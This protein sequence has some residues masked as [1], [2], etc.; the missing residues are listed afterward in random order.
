M[1][2]TGSR[3]TKNINREP[4]NVMITIGIFYG[5]LTAGT[6]GG[7]ANLIAGGVALLIRLVLLSLIA[8]LFMIPQGDRANRFFKAMSVLM[9]IDGAMTIMVLLI[10]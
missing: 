1:Q 10:L 3:T 8:L 6:N 5:L 2:Q 7:P 4:V 9:I